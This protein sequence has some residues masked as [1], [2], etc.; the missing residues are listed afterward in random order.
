MMK[1]VEIALQHANC[2]S[3]HSPLQLRFVIP[4]P[5]SLS[6]CP[7]Q[8][9]TFY[10]RI[11][12]LLLLVT[13]NSAGPKKGKKKCRHL[14]SDLKSYWHARRKQ[15]GIHPPQPIYPTVPRKPRCR[16]VVFCQP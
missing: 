2:T 9:M 3:E 8:D 5:H 13:T 1:I 12:L 16:M 11:L 6:I 10:Q 7:L 4:H 14:E 15:Y